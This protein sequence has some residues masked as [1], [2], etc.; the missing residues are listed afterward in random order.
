M[1]FKTQRQ[2]RIA[3]FLFS[4]SCAGLV[5]DGG[6]G[7]GEETEGYVSLPPE[8][9]AAPLDVTAPEVIAVASPDAGINGHRPERP[10]M[11]FAGLG[12]SPVEDEVSKAAVDPTSA[13]FKLLR[14]SEAEAPKLHPSLVAGGEAVPAETTGGE[15]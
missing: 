11:P 5:G 3:A 10:E 8:T 2:W 15:Q 14:E 6:L 1:F 13:L 9:M 7:D 4:V 12:M